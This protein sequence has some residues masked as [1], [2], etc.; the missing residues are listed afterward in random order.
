MP[1]DRRDGRI[2]NEGGEGCRGGVCEIGADGKEVIG[3]ESSEDSICECCKLM[4]AD[5]GADQEV[6]WVAVLV[7]AASIMWPGAIPCGVVAMILRPLLIRLEDLS[8]SIT[9]DSATGCVGT[10]PTKTL[11]ACEDSC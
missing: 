4:K 8:G 11:N 1:D 3:T 2:G 7:S 10:P 6:A 9:C 5:A